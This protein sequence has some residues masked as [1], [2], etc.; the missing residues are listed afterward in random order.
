MRAFSAPGKALLAGGYLVLDPKY[1]SFVIALSARMHAVVTSVKNP[2]LKDETNIHI[3]SS[4]FNHNEWNYIAS[5][6]RGFAPK[7]IDG[8]SNPFIEY[9]IINVCNYFF[10]IEADDNDITIEIF[11]DEEYH[12][13]ENTKVMKNTYKSFRFHDK[14]IQDVPKTGLGSSAGLVTVLTTALSSIFCKNLDISQHQHQ[15][16]I[17]NLAQI[18]HC[19]AQGKI[20]SG[21]DVAAATYGSIVYRRFFPD[22]ISDLPK[23]S[24]DDLDK[25]HTALRAVVD[26]SDWK[27]TATPT[28][29]PKGFKLI[30]GDVNTGS[31]TVKLVQK[32]KSW[33]NENL[34]SSLN[35]YKSID[36]NNMKIIKL[37]QDL[38]ILEKTNPTYYNDL[39]EGLSKGKIQNF[40]EL[41]EF[42]NAVSEIRK[43][44]RLITEQSGA[45]IEPAVQ[46]ELLD[47]CCKLKGVLTGVIPGAGG[48]DAIALVASQDTDIALETKDLKEFQ[49][50]TWMKLRQANCGLSE[51]DS[52]HYRDLKSEC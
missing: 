10:D 21:F 17:H 29:L 16:L 50:V 7:E 33:Y 31:E 46:T 44:F 28:N 22:I 47:N 5:K 48:F 19:Q 4:Q 25:Y 15:R 20:G 39:L 9:T 40:K 35:V 38:H 49:N 52:D 37:C 2:G 3:K 30:M 41:Q 26:N 45:D 43:N 18:A 36:S 14:D 6:V 8:K 27:M 12:S 42:Q 24:T 13:K 23:I 32:V 34:P 51:E 11:S 1:E